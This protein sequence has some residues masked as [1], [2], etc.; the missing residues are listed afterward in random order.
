MCCANPFTFSGWEVKPI[1]SLLR[2]WVVYRQVIRTKIHNFFT[3]LDYKGHWIVAMERV[4]AMD[5]LVYVSIK[6]AYYQ[7]FKS[8][9][10]NT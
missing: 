1:P 8:L 2:G 3:A 6:L 9:K 4:F 10:N 7:V 5:S